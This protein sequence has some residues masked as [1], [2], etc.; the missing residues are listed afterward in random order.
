MIPDKQQ[1]PKL[2][3]IDMSGPELEVRHTDSSGQVWRQAPSWMM[4]SSK[5]MIRTL[6]RQGL[7][8]QREN[9][10]PNRW[11]MVEYKTPTGEWRD[12]TTK[13]GRRGLAGD[14][15]LPNTKKAKKKS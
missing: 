5:D 8:E 7:K 12:T 11:G 6:G 13:E 3:P 1:L 9:P 14:L 10:D 15:G 4:G 2:T